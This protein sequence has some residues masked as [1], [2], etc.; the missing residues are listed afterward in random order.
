MLAFIAGLGYFV[1]QR[2]IESEQRLFAISKELETARSI[3]Q[4]ILPA[5]T[6]SIADLQIS[7]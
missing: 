2:A 7:V 4:S 5:K 3:Q 6:P 1:A